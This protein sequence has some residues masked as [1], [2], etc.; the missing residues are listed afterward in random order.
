[1]KDSKNQIIRSMKSYEVGGAA[2][3]S[4]MEEYTDASGKKRKRRKSG[5]GKVTKFRTSS[6]SS[7]NGGGALSALLGIGA[8]VGAGLGLK[9]MLKKEK[10]GGPVKKKMQLGGSM[11]RNPNTGAKCIKNPKRPLAD[12]IGGN[13]LGSNI[14]DMFTQKNRP[15]SRSKKLRS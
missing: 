13:K 4:C 3:T 11:G 10:V 12:G 14:K 1:M 7:G 6:G 9:K 8:G 15:S 2:D 5:C